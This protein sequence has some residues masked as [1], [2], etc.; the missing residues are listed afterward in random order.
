MEKRKRN[1]WMFTAAN[2]LVAVAM[3]Y[4]LNRAFSVSRPKEVPYSEFLS[5]V[6]AG[7]MAE[8]QITDKTLLGVLKEQKPNSE[9]SPASVHML[10]ATR[11]PGINEATLL[12]DVSIPRQSRGL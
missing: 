2:V 7:H 8:V 11:L 6:R 10:K 3:I 9:N 4:A 12:K 5:E 1:S